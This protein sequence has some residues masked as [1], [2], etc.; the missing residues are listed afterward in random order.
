[1]IHESACHVGLNKNEPKLMAKV[2]AILTEAKKDGELNGI[3]EKWLH[4]PLPVKM[5]QSTE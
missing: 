3:V 1:V 5:A 2:D 4:V